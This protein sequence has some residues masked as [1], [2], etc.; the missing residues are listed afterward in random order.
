MGEPEVSSIAKFDQPSSAQT[1]HQ[2]HFVD[3][4]LPAWHQPRTEKFNEVKQAILSAKDGLTIALH[5]AGGYGKSTLAEALCIDPKVR[6]HFPDGIVWLQFNEDGKTTAESVLLANIGFI[7]PTHNETHFPDL[8]KAT[9]S[10]RKAVGKKRILLVLDDV[11]RQSQITPFWNPGPNCVCLMTTRNSGLLLPSAIRIEIDQLTTDEG[12]ALLSWGLN[13]ENG[14]LQ[15]ILKLLVEQ[16]GRWTLLLELANG[17]FRS[18][19]SSG[20]ELTDGI[21]EFNSYLYEEGVTFLDTFDADE[22]QRQKRNLAIGYCIEASLRLFQD[23]AL[24]RFQELGIFPEDADIPFT[25]ISDLWKQTSGISKTNSM[26]LLKEFRDRGLIKKYNTADHSLRLHK[27][28]SLYLVDIL[29]KAE[30]LEIIHNSLVIAFRQY[31]TDGWDSLPRDKKYARS[32]LK[33]HLFWAGRE[34]E[35]RRIWM[36]PTFKSNGYFYDIRNGK[37]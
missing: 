4:D 30:K 5:G 14:T 6:T 32:H 9:T 3:F 18:F 23:E 25:V 10:L 8:S 31:C 17:W 24:A 34:K 13:T 22:T 36:K 33:F 11:W 7:V 16:L 26:M 37:V 2:P 20:G 28:I 35:A 27:A 19:C 1:A 29:V 21:I 15:Q 12:Y